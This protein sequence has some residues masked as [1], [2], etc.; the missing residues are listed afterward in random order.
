MSDTRPRSRSPTVKKTSSD[1]PK[2]GPPPHLRQMQSVFSTSASQSPNLQFIS[3]HTEKLNRQ[4]KAKPLSYSEPVQFAVTKT[5]NGFTERRVRAEG[6]ATKKR[7]VSKYPRKD[8][9]TVLSSRKPVTTFVPVDAWAQIFRR[10]D[11]KFLLQA[12]LVCRDFRDILTAQSIWRDARLYNHGDSVPS[13]PV[14]LNERQYVNLL[15]GKGC[16]V[17]PC[18]QSLTKKVYWA[19]MMRMCESCFKET[20][21]R[22][23]G[24]SEEALL[25]CELFNRLDPEIKATLPTRLSE[26]LPASNALSIGGVYAQTRPLDRD[27]QIWRYPD[28]FRH[29]CVRIYD[30]VILKQNFR[31]NVMVEPSAF[32]PWARRIWK[33]TRERVKVA[34]ELDVAYRDLFERPRNIR[35]QKEEFFL[36]QAGALTPPMTRAVLEKM[37]AYNRVLDTPN[38]ASQ[39]AWDLL[40][41]KIDRPEL[42]AQAEQLLEWDRMDRE[43][44]SWAEYEE[45]VDDRLEIHRGK[46]LEFKLDL[47]DIPEKSTEQKAIVAIAVKSLAKLLKDN[48]HDEDLLLMLLQ[49]VRREYETMEDKPEGMNSDGA[50]G[51]YQLMLD[52]ARM[53]VEE[54]LKP[55]A[56]GQGVVQSKRVL[57]SLRCMGCIR[58]DCHKTYNFTNLFIHIRQVHSCYVEAEKHYWRIAVP[59]K[60]RIR[61]YQ[62]SVAWYQIPWPKSFPALPYHRRAMPDIEWNPDIEEDYVQHEPE[63]AVQFFQH[64]QVI[65]QQQTLYHS[66]AGDLIEAVK[67]FLHTRLDPDGVIRIAL[68][69]AHRRQAERRKENPRVLKIS[70]S[71]LQNWE[72]LLKTITPKFVLRFKCGL[73]VKDPKSGSRGKQRRETLYSQPLQYLVPHWHRK[74]R[75]EDD[76]LETELIVLPSDL[77]LQNMITAEDKKLVTEHSRILK[78]QQITSDDGSPREKHEN[79]TPRERALLKVPTIQSQLNL[80]FESNDLRNNSK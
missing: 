6:P 46:T 40:A 51:E 52:D 69:Y 20:T 74:H 65:R 44:L 21:Q 53:I 50:C 70:I 45:D 10:S 24:E 14:G 41:P 32:L 27:S 62:D 35:E 72:A 68:E 34:R 12:R 36:S 71:Q 5:L 4:R 60:S 19:F 33:V 11:L 15:A 42:R 9:E 58:K 73:C 55:H 17:K 8:D 77:T 47:M 38:A 64:L 16:Q 22:Q 29:Y 48:V 26:L 56:L 31:R 66:H 43:I 25:Y 23:D 75:L 57:N 79:F 59:R 7:K 37:A 13:C 18:A 80:L 54:V 49:A 28:D 61:R 3:S 67:V 1:S 2:L 30:Y 76:T 63:G 78:K 39:R